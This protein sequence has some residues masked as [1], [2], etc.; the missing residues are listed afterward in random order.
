MNKFTFIALVFLVVFATSSQAQILIDF[1]SDAPGPQPNGFS[2]ADAPGV[3]FTDSQGADL[4]VIDGGNQ[5]DGQGL[6]VFGDDPS[7]LLIDLGTFVDSISL[8]FGNDDPSVATA[9]DVAHLAV[10]DGATLVGETSVEMNLDDIMNQTI[11]FSGQ[12]FNR[13]EFAYAD[14]TLTPIGLIE[15]VDNIVIGEE[16][17]VAPPAPPVPVPADGPWALMLLMI[18]MA[19]VGVMRLNQ[20]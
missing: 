10:F 4:E 3:T 11:S 6:A 18:A 8:D 7:I 9:G 2:S 17:E 15:A 16:V 20:N 5:T 19:A 14:A 1:E 13:A 12:P